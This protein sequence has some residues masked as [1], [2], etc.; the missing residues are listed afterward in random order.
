[1]Q[2]QVPLDPYTGLWSRVR[3]FDPEAF[4][5]ELTDRRLVRMTLMRAT[6]HVVTAADAQRLRPA[7][8]TMLER[9][10]AASPFARELAGVEQAQIVE[11]GIELVEREPLTVARLGAALSQEW[12]DRAPDA[13]AYA[14][15]YLAPLVQVT[16]RGVWGRAMQPTITT[17]RSWLEATDQAAAVSVDELVQR[18]LRA[19]GPA[20]SADVRTW[21]GL[22]DLQTVVA[23]LRPQLRSYRDE[24]GRELHDVADGTFADRRPAAVPRRRLEARGAGA[25]RNAGGR[26]AHAASRL[27]AG[28]GAG[29]GRAAARVP[30]PAR[31]DPAPLVRV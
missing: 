22:T 13:L 20:T 27:R 31:P 5:W 6:L 11:R 14:V 15:R 16:P 1:M 26:G 7:L 23:R 28:R 19:F 18:Y 3:G 30:H 10:F 25:G 9:A 21:S 2:A 29:R 4:G 17:L 24:A 8:Q 12:P